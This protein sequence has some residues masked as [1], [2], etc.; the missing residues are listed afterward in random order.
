[1][2]TAAIEYEKAYEKFSAEAK[3]EYERWGTITEAKTLRE[4]AEKASEAAVDA[5]LGKPGT[6]EYY[7]VCGYRDLLP[8]LH[9]YYNDTE[10][11][12]RFE[13]ELVQD[14]IFHLFGLMGHSCR[15]LKN[16]P[17]ATGYCIRFQR[18][19]VTAQDNVKLSKATQKKGHVDH[20][21]NRV[22]RGRV[23]G[24]VF[25][26]KK[27]VDEA[28]EAI[29][30]EIF[31][32]P[33]WLPEKPPVSAPPPKA[34]PEAPN[35]EDYAGIPLP[36]GQFG[37]TP[38][39]T[40]YE[41]MFLYTPNELDPNASPPGDP[42]LAIENPLGGYAAKLLKWK[43]KL[44]DEEKI[45]ESLKGGRISEPVRYSP[46]DEE[47]MYF[48]SYLTNI[49]FNV[50]EDP[51][52]L[53]YHKEYE[54]TLK[55]AAMSLY[56]DSLVV[57]KADVEASKEWEEPLQE[58]S[59]IRKR[60]PPGDI[61]HQIDDIGVLR[62]GEIPGALYPEG[63][64]VNGWIMTIGIRRSK[65][66]QAET[67]TP[68]KNWWVPDTV[69][70][71]MPYLN[72]GLWPAW[73]IN[74]KKEFP[75]N[76]IKRW[77]YVYATEY[78]YENL[79]YD[80]ERL[81][82]ERQKA[83]IE[84]YETPAPGFPAKMWDAKHCDFGF[85]KIP[86]SNRAAIMV[87]ISERWADDQPLKDSA[88]PGVLPPV[89]ELPKTKQPMPFRNWRKAIAPHPVWLDNN[90]GTY[91]TVVEALDENEFLKPKGKK[92]GGK[93][94]PDLERAKEVLG[95][96]G[97]EKIA[98]FYGKNP[99]ANPKVDPYEYYLYFLEHQIDTEVWIGHRP[100]DVPRVIVG[101]TKELIDSLPNKSRIPEAKEILE[102]NDHF[103]ETEKL[104]ILRM[105]F[106][107]QLHRQAFDEK[108]A[109][110]SR[111]LKEQAAE[112]D[113]TERAGNGLTQRQLKRCA[114]RV[115]NFSSEFD[116]YVIQ[117]N[118][119]WI[120]QWSHDARDH[121]DNGN[122]LAYFLYLD[123]ETW[124][125]I[126]VFFLGHTRLTKGLGEFKTSWQPP[127]NFSLQFIFWA[128]Q[129]FLST[130]RGRSKSFSD[131][132]FSAMSILFNPLGA[133]G[134]LLSG[135]PDIPGMPKNFLGGTVD[136]EVAK[137]LKRPKSA[138]RGYTPEQLKKIEEDRK[139]LQTAVGRRLASGKVGAHNLERENPGAAFDDFI[140]MMYD[141]VVAGGD[142]MP[143]SHVFQSVLGQVNIMNLIMMYLACLGL[144]WPFEI[145][146][147]WN[148]SFPWFNIPW[149]WFTIPEIPWLNW[150]DILDII[151]RIIIAIIIQLIIMLILFIIKEIL[152]FI[153][154]LL[155]CGG[156]GSGGDMPAMPDAPFDFGPFDPERML[157]DALA[158]KGALADGADLGLG[159]PTTPA[160]LANALFAQCGGLS[161]ED[162][163]KDKN[164]LIYFKDMAKILTGV[165]FCQLMHGEPNIETLKVV[166]DYT[167]NHY[168]K[169]Y[170]K[171][172]APYPGHAS[173]YGSHDLY[174]DFFACLGQ[175][176][177]KQ[178]DELCNP[179]ALI[180][181]YAQK[182]LDEKC[183][184]PAHQSSLN[185]KLK[186]L[187]EDKGLEPEDIE[188]MIEAADA[189]LINKLMD[190]EALNTKVSEM[191]EVIVPKVTAPVVNSIQ[192]KGFDQMFKPIAH[193]FNMGIH[194]LQ[195]DTFS[196][197]S[198]IQLMTNFVIN[199]KGFKIVKSGHWHYRRR[200]RWFTTTYY[201]DWYHTTY[202]QGFGSVF[203]PGAS[204]GKSIGP[205]DDA[206]IPECPSDPIFV[207]KKWKIRRQVWPS[208]D[209][210]EHVQ[211]MIM[212]FYGMSEP[213]F[214]RVFPQDVKRFWR[215]IG[216]PNYYK[217]TPVPNSG[218]V[219]SPYVGPKWLPM[220]TPNKWYR[221]Q[222]NLGFLFEMSD[223]FAG[224]LGDVAAETRTN[225]DQNISE[226]VKITNGV[227]SLNTKLNANGTAFTY[228]IQKAT[229]PT[230]DADGNP[231]D[232]GIKQ[233][234]NPKTVRLDGMETDKDGNPTNA[235][236]PWWHERKVTE[237]TEI[238]GEKW[239]Q[240]SEFVE[241]FIPEGHP[242]RTTS[243][244][245]SQASKVFTDIHDNFYVPEIDKKVVEP[246]RRSP[247]ETFWLQEYYDAENYTELLEGYPPEETT[248]AL[249][250]DKDDP[251]WR[252]SD[253]RHRAK[254]VM[255]K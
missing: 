16:G 220:W 228:D 21:T 32:N 37:L 35:S 9:N 174:K 217:W 98:D 108:L 145:P 209:L 196:P 226:E 255:K 34:D 250:F 254:E 190:M 107:Y 158:D 208:P 112:L 114:N 229:P 165:E 199:A 151:R 200:R 120:D 45:L 123:P 19:T 245:E 72:E 103:Q 252:L 169:I 117:Q 133:L 168:P 141:D 157:D 195:Q 163:G 222:G 83:M 147:L 116:L 58:G 48:V 77:Y 134:D 73:K 230:V 95:F 189:D 96:R 214:D 52:F 186:E 160:E 142:G 43:S 59:P 126:D 247:M 50:H 148:F 139:K 104:L 124:N 66:K 76:V 231:L 197:D 62:V 218:I 65:I 86:F 177:A 207:D 251:Y 162:Y 205:S 40:R 5:V 3:R 241:R 91:Y 173:Q 242:L 84:L 121:V 144:E 161:E 18:L 179:E 44:I 227:L 4:K 172:G 11:I 150:V 55:S 153:L 67:A 17:Q 191:M 88:E 167:K 8:H 79:L 146:C 224:V 166:I 13:D 99:K 78:E 110:V 6:E 246:I 26:P 155:G 94:K 244:W 239:I 170:K 175:L 193:S 140:S 182:M 22:A 82:R 20:P 70:D 128:Q 206:T 122:T 232:D 29:A 132:F 33:V 14:L 92:P 154:G 204:A 102:M 106:A 113:K 237:P 219:G 202:K 54:N 101:V 80:K 194:R 131:Y 184:I 46:K 176:L 188:K 180:E 156:G 109:I 213:M 243:A 39:K 51:E 63:Q 23:Y 233:I 118:D 47:D 41:Q 149:P 60:P 171:I 198:D 89:A 159:V 115:Q 57:E 137:A 105:T 127:Q 75:E 130:H 10:A 192:M 53:Y 152:A 111:S 210:P 90:R 136:A 24:C 49:N 203:Y 201:K 15:N 183:E 93:R 119:I 38:E 61:T 215:V 71:W 138:S 221:D 64:T 249:F 36:V 235:K 100:T 1:E 25:I 240:K 143:G 68:D 125:I 69:F 185:D 28:P 12:K 97:F 216:Y 129:V 238:D 236:Y 81:H 212:N 85:A 181:R 56:H 234:L 87:A 135:L 31:I 164:A 30:S 42:D 248:R 27:V 253:I 74:P 223:T 187:W 178:V 7:S 211:Q 225:F 2:D